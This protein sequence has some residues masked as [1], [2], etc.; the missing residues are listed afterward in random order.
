MYPLVAT[1]FV[2]LFGTNGFLVLHALLLAIV[3]GAGYLFLAAR[4][5]PPVA[6][7][8]A[9]GF[10]LASVTPGL[11]GLDDARAVQ[12]GRGD[13]RLL[14]LAVQV[15]GAWRPRSAAAAGSRRAPPMSWRRVLIGSGDVL[16]ATERTVD[17]ARSCT[18]RCRGAAGDAAVAIGSPSAWWSAACSR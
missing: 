5:P 10:F 13:A 2:W 3:I 7:L 18:A 6:L 15:S 4:S 9:T 12:P 14:L 16:E 17:R 8:L 1:P 11:S